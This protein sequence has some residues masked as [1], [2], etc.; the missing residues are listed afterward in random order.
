MKI[1]L[2]YSGI[3]ILSIVIKATIESVSEALPVF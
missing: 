1:K 2:K 3:A